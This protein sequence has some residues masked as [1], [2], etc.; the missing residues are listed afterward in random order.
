MAIAY[1]PR[2]LAHDTTPSPA[3]LVRGL[4]LVPATAVILA[5]IIGTGVF[6][7]ARVM[8]C[9]VGSPAMVLTV[10]VVAGLLSLAGAMV[11]AELSAMIPRAG[12]EVHFLAAAYGRLWAFM[13]GWTKTIALGASF[14]AISILTVT[15]LN[16]LTGHRLPTWALGVLPVGVIALCTAINLITVHAS[17]MVATLL[18]IVKVGLVLMISVGAFFL[19]D[20]SW[21]HF[22]ATADAGIREGVAPGAQG[23][24]AGFG[25]AMLGALW[26]YNGWNGVVSLGGEIRHPG[27]TLPRALIG[28]TLLV[29]VLYLL[30]NG[31]YFFALSPEEVA[32]VPTSST[33][34]FEV[35][36]RF[37]GPMA[38]GVM[39]ACLMVSAY[40]SLHAGFLMGSRVPFT[41]ARGGMLPVGLGKLSSQ[42][43]PIVAVIVLGIWA[44]VLALTG[45]FDMLTDIYIFVIWIFYGLIG[46]TVFVLRRTMPEAE[47]PYRVWG[48]P[49]VPALFLLVTAFL[50]INT[51]IATPGRALAGF[52][53]IGIGLPVYWHYARRLGPAVATRDWSDAEPE[54]V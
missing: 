51:V 7:K 23:G 45:T 20:G 33:V 3:H 21:S 43:V 13:F 48:Y 30:I 37:L 50:L 1:S 11:Y 28:G 39:S 41:I 54:D 6:V 53:L 18:T 40:G 9:N 38:A 36:A 49:V 10:W 35:A 15:F 16:D 32:S 44:S 4:T 26:A 8:T 47:R 12:G 25:A 52:A 34:A 17:G 29:I 14:A 22:G 19:A 24:L 31:A 42:G 5:N 27:R 46:S 2:I